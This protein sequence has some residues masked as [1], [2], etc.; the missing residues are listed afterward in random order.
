[1]PGE[2]LANFIPDA[3]FDG[4]VSA[5][6]LDSMRSH[7]VPAYHQGLLEGGYDISADELHYYV[8]LA[9][10][11]YVWLAPLLLQRAMEGQYSAYGNVDL[12]TAQ[13]QED[14]Y[15]ERGLCLLY[16]CDWLDEILA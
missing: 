5:D 14:Q 4:F 12:A 6:Q 15:R 9:A 7:L 1:M 8:G 10:I 16:L 2:D 11:K 3:V 13:Q